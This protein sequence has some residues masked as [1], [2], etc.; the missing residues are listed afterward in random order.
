MSLLGR[1]RVGNL[2]EDD[3][4]FWGAE[5]SRAPVCVLDCNG[6]DDGL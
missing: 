2:G 5:V 3:T 1:G 4:A 6:S